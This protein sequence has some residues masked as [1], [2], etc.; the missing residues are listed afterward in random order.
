MAFPSNDFAQATCSSE[1]ERSYIYHKMNRTVNAFPSF[2]KVTIS[3]PGTAEVFTILQRGGGPGKMVEWNYH[4]FLVGSNG[5]FVASYDS[6][7]DPMTAEPDV[8]K[9]LGLSPVEQKEEDE[10]L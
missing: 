6:A 8:R 10:Q 7:A 3:G 1:C 5:T 4:K 2:D 9:A